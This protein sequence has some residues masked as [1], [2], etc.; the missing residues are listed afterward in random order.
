METK[1]GIT[2]KKN[3]DYSEW[4]TQVISEQGAKLADIRYGVQGFVVIR[5]WAMATIREIYRLLEE[6]FEQDG[7]MP[8]LFPMVIPQKN[9]AKEKEHVEGFMG[10]VMEITRA[11]GEDLEESLI[12]RPTGETQFYPM[13]SYWVRSHNDLPLKLYQSRHTVVRHGFQTRPFLRGREFVFF[14]SHDVFKNHDEAME[15]IYT[16]MRITD[17]VYWVECA[18]PFIYFVRPQWD[19]FPGAVNTFAI[20]ILMP[21]GKVSQAGTTHDLGQKFSKMYDIKF[22]SEEEKEEYAWQTCFGPG[23]A[24]IYASLVSVHGDDKG[25][26]FPYKMAPKQVIVVPILRKDEGVNKKINRKALDLVDML[27]QNGIR[28]DA[29]LTEKSPGFKYNEWEMKGVPFRIELGQR[30]MESGEFTV[31]MRTGEKFKVK[32]EELLDVLHDKADDLLDILQDRAKEMHDSFIS[33]TEDIEEVVSIL[34]GKRGYIK[35]PFCSMDFDGEECADKLKEKAV[36]AEVRGTRY[37]EPERVKSGQKCIVC[38][39]DAKH[40]VYIAK[41]Y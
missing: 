22:F 18:L 2:V 21:D 10:E 35:A 27:T 1:Q 16:D 8:V 38:G 19:K 24:R 25:L 40:I 4:Y 36:G 5:P 41:S 14:E 39:K 3:E 37:P 6:Q 9:F 34:A 20:D 31:A 11:G 12:V 13:Y 26:I 28:A 29:D 23:I 33:E 7:H 17:K 32:E 30:E 15:Q